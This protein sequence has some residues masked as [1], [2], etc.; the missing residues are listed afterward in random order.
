L[1]AVDQWSGAPSLS[2]IANVHTV[3]G[4]VFP[5]SP[6]AATKEE[7]E[8]MA[9]DAEN[10]KQVLEQLVETLQQQLKGTQ[11]F[12]TEKINH[13][14]EQLKQANASIDQ[15]QG[16]LVEAHSDKAQLT[17]DLQNL[18]EASAKQAAIQKTHMDMLEV[19]MK[20]KDSAEKQLRTDAKNVQSDLDRLKQEL[21]EAQRIIEELMVERNKL[22]GVLDT[23]VRKGWLRKKSPNETLGK[24]L[25]T[26][27]FVLKGITLCYYKSDKDDLSHPKG[28]IQLD[29]CQVLQ[30]SASDAL[31]KTG[32]NTAFELRQ[33]SNNRVYTFVAQ[34]A[35]DLK[36]WIE[37]M[38]RVKLIHH[39]R[40]EWQKKLSE[41]PAKS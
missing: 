39:S 33:F 38:T 37:T 27:Y 3:G 18:Q 20:Q 41:K 24:K 40:T 13:L 15:L 19:T 30:L 16:E 14:E 2:K 12:M 32:S 35:Q 21:E 8:K 26:R 34:D 36:A 31:E 28:T 10:G 5:G 29:H 23:V 4:I 25:Q 9:R 6:L 1:L 7:L 22:D 17:T 11:E